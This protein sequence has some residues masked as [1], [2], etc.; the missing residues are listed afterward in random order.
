MISARHRL[1]SAVVAAAVL[2]AWVGVGRADEP[3]LRGWDYL[4]EKLVADDVPRARAVATFTDPRMPRFTGLEFSVAPRESAALY[5][6]LLKPRTVSAARRCRARYEDALG[7]AEATEGV[8]ANVLAAL[9]YVES[10]CGRMTGNARVLPRLARLSMANAPENL[11]ANLERLGATRTPEAAV[12][13]RARYLEDT[14]YPEVRGTFDVADRQGLDPLELVGSEGGAFG[15]PQF[16]P[17]SFLRYGVDADGDGRVRL[18]DM[19]DAAASCARYLAHHG[20]KPGCSRR[21]RQHALWAYNHS[22][23]YVSAV[24]ALADRLGGSPAP[25]VHQARAARVKGRPPA[26]HATR[27]APRPASRRTRPSLARA[28]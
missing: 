17:T 26:A 15:Y 12:R 25:V 19:A 1:A 20:W 16:L 10:G 24:L 13:A 4:V 23:P 11:A 21:E 7:A 18:D 6:G 9:L 2:V 27:R 8:P 14:F 28:H 3:D 5:R 22:D